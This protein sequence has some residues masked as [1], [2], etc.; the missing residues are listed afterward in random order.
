VTPQIF[1]LMLVGIFV[2]ERLKC[3]CTLKTVYIMSLG[4]FNKAFKQKITSFEIL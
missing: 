3:L 4:L 1:K 2:I